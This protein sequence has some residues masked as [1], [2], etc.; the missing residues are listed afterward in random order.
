MRII[1]PESLASPPHSHIS[2]KEKLSTEQVLFFLRGRDAIHYLCNK[3]SIGKGD[4]VLAPALICRSATDPI[5]ATGASV[6]FVDM[7]EDLDYDQAL[8]EKTFVQYR[9]KALFVVHHFGKRP[10]IEQYRELCDKFGS[11]LIED[12]CHSL[13]SAGDFAADISGDYA[14]YS[15]RKFLPIPDGGMLVC[16]KAGLSL[17][18][19]CSALSLVDHSKFL[20]RH[21][22]KKIFYSGI[23]NPY[24][25]QQWKKK[26]VGLRKPRFAHKLNEEKI[27]GFSIHYALPQCHVSQFL[28]KWLDSKNLFA[29]IEKHRHNYQR[30]SELL[31]ADIVYRPDSFINSV[32]VAFPIVDMSPRT[33]LLERL[34]ALGIGAYA[35]P[36]NDLPTEVRGRYSEAEKFAKHLV[37][38]PI[39]YGLTEDDLLHVASIVKKEVDSISH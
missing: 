10:K 27:H 16:R 39:H 17:P 21:I 5:F 19:N 34:R 37:M 20:L 2:T 29:V 9:P 25:F 38:L 8:L 14:I 35:W 33:D 32:P 26:L 11:I 13:P 15:L 6:K 7:A 3:L 4:C 30:M 28:C 23:H 31:S 36:G 12:R 24:I 18:N 22:G 1:P